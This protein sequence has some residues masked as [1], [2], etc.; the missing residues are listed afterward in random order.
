M[1]SPLPLWLIICW[2]F[3]QT[4]VAALFFPAASTLQLTVLVS[5][6]VENPVRKIYWDWGIQ[7]NYDLP[8]TP[9]NFINVPIWPNKWEDEFEEEIRRRRGLHEDHDKSVNHTWW[10]IAEKY[11]EDVANKHPSDFTAGEFYYAMENLLISYGFHET[12]LLRSVCELARH[13]FDDAQ[14]NLLTEILTFV[15]SPSL[16]EAFSDTEILYRDV[17]EAAERNGFL[18]YNCAELYSECEEDLLTTLTNI[19]DISHSNS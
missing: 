9:Q 7:A 18:H 16:H 15:L 4:S 10:R 12:C 5:A 11:N 3:T 14:K 8:Y 17:Y 2:Q 6:P 1:S 13:P 19:I